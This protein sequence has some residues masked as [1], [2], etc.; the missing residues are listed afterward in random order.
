[1]CRVC[2][3]VCVCVAFSVSALRCGKQQ[4]PATVFSAPLSWPD[5]SLSSSRHSQRNKKKKK[6]K[7][8]KKNR[9]FFFSLLLFSSFFSFLFCCFSF[10][11]RGPRSSRAFQRRR[12]RRRSAEDAVGFVAKLFRARLGRFGPHRTGGGR[13]FWFLVCFFFLRFSF[14]F[15]PRAFFEN[16]ADRWRQRR[17]K[18]SADE[19][20]VVGCCRWI[21]FGVKQKQKWDVVLPDLKLR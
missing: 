4:R 3:C 9:V 17:S 11:R 14:H 13:F 19:V 5:V 20:D 8:K 7:K 16:G 6:K 12:R 1:M 21:D 10:P 15:E 2:V 18:D